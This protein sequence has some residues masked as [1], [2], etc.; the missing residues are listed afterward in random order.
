MDE[1][2]T[3]L[4]I[5]WKW[6]LAICGMIVAVGGAAA[7]LAKLLA[8]IKRMEARI[9]ALEKKHAKDQEENVEKLSQD[10]RDIDRLNESNR[11]ICEC[12]LALMDH[13]ITGNSIERLKQARND[14]NSFLINR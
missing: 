5:L 7:I 14:L 10:H 8:P 6:V 4:P 12:M 1:V 9:E 13:E 11:H 2:M 3:T